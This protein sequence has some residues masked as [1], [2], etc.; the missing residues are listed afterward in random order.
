LYSYHTYFNFLFMAVITPPF[1]PRAGKR[2][3]LKDAARWTD[4]FRRDHNQPT[5]KPTLS[6]DFGRDFL[7]EML[8]EEPSC[9]GLRF[10]QAID[11]A[12]VRRVVVVGVDEK[13]NDLLP[14]RMSDGTLPD[15]DGD[16]VGETPNRC[17]DNCD[18]NSP[19]MQ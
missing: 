5:E 10:Y 13:G 6:H 16:Q 9:A 1:D 7:L 17:P 11:D 12:G 3:K 18:P 2:M 14:R 15:N 4:N 19:L 8:A